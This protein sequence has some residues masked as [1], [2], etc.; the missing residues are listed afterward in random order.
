MA[1]VSSRSIPSRG[2]H[3]PG[4]TTWVCAAQVGPTV[5][6]CDSARLTH[7]PMLCP[8]LLR[9]RTTTANAPK[10]NWRR[11]HLSVKARDASASRSPCS[12]G[13]PRRSQ[14]TLGRFTGT[15]G[16][17]PERDA[18]VRDVRGRRASFW[19]LVEVSSCKAAED[20][21]SSEHE[22]MTNQNGGFEMSNVKTDPSRVFDGERVWSEMA[23]IQVL[24]A[25]TPKGA[26]WVCLFGLTL[27]A[28]IRSVLRASDAVNSSGGTLL[29]YLAFY[30]A[31]LVGLGSVTVGLGSLATSPR[32]VWRVA[33]NRRVGVRRRTQDLAPEESRAAYVLL[34]VLALVDSCA[35]A[36]IFMVLPTIN[37]TVRWRESWQIVGAGISLVLLVLSP[38]LL[39]LNLR[40]IVLAKGSSGAILSRDHTS[41]ELDHARRTIRARGGFLGGD[42]FRT[43]LGTALFM[44]WAQERKSARIHNYGDPERAVDRIDIRQAPKMYLVTLTIVYFAAFLVGA[45]VTSNFQSSSKE[46]GLDEMCVTAITFGLLGLPTGFWLLTTASIRVDNANVVRFKD[47]CEILSAGITLRK[48][49]LAGAV[50]EILR[51]LAKVEGSVGDL[52]RRNVRWWRPTVLL[53][54]GL[55]LCCFRTRAQRRRL[56]RG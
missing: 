10:R 37:D 45:T 42:G 26:G 4:S 38:A 8:H 18:I 41:E 39:A 14:P 32:G 40:R 31:I 28:T 53:S 30:A 29:V 44:E 2:C 27:G 12:A 1:A 49:P 20:K 33:P 6:G 55:L 56:F 9:G 43:K 35:I 47:A 36:W 13:R 25:W 50:D 19:T 52:N 21:A 11:A 48:D 3:S 51:A 24:P 23:D 5:K 16:P 17:R 22:L 15:R 54:V 34:P 46:I 7:P